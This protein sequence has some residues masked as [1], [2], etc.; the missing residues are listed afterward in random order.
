MY[1]WVPDHHAE[2][3]PFHRLNHLRHTGEG[4]QKMIC[5]HILPP[6]VLDVV[7]LTAASLSVRTR[8]LVVAVGLRRGLDREL[9]GLFLI[10]VASTVDA[11]HFDPSPVRR[12]LPPPTRMISGHDHLAGLAQG[13][14]LETYLVGAPFLGHIHHVV[15]VLVLV[16]RSST[17]GMRSK[18]DHLLG[19]LLR[20]VAV[21][22]TV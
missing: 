12:R 13:P 17:H 21:E 16:P 22:E 7:R 9:V 15:L 14:L 1:R 2:G 5:L 8:Q 10:H 19:L 4:L 20:F 3:F 6:F 18:N 11:H